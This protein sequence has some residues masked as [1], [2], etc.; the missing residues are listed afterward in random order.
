VSPTIP[1]HSLIYCPAVSRNLSSLESPAWVVEFA[2]CVRIH[3]R[4]LVKHKVRMAF[5]SHRT[6]PSAFYKSYTQSWTSYVVGVLV[7]S[8]FRFWNID[9]RIGET[10]GTGASAFKNHSV[11]PAADLHPLYCLKS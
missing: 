5:H 7:E 3:T 4:Y 1:N 11:S 8:L 2:A 9:L 6:S 10:R